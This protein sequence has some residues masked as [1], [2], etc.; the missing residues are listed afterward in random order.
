MLQVADLGTLRVLVNNAGGWLPGPQYPEAREWRRSIDLNLVVPMLTTQLAV[1]LMT[2]AG[3]SPWTGRRYPRARHRVRLERGHAQ[4]A[5]VRLPAPGRRPLAPPDHVSN[6]LDLHEKAGIQLRIL[7]NLWT[8][9]DAVTATN[10]AFSGIRLR[11]ARPRL[12]PGGGP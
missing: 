8:F 1:P 4:H 5:A 6:L 3:G 12:S 10:P 2:N 7:P 9:W 11:N